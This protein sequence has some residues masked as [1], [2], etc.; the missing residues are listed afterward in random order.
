[1]E[2]PGFPE[3]RIWKYRTG[4]HE[5]NRNIVTISEYSKSPLD[6]NNDIHKYYN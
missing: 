3:L 1:M 6:N 2:T 5:M 4:D